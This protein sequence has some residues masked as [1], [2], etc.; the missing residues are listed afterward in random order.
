MD[1]PNGSVGFLRTRIAVAIHDG[2]DGVT[3][4]S[5]GNRLRVGGRNTE[6]FAQL[7]AG[8][9]TLTSGMDLSLA[10]LVGASISSRKGQNILC[11]P[12]RPQMDA[13]YSPFRLLNLPDAVHELECIEEAVRDR[14][15]PV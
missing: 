14:N 13:L 3:Q 4:L 10:R 7:L 5:V 12:P 15:R 2:L 8:Q 1:L 6:L 9:M 11:A